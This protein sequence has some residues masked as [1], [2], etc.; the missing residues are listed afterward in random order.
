MQKM[1]VKRTHTDQE[2][3]GGNPRETREG[4]TFEAEKVKDY[5]NT[6]GKACIKE[7]LPE[8]CN[9]KRCRSL[10]YVRTEENTGE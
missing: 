3:D 4:E 5:T 10:F 7:V 2:N 8:L 1:L 6:I 9:K